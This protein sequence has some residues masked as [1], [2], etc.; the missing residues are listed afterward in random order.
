MDVLFIN[1][2]NASGIYQDLSK[3]YAAVEPPTWALLLAQSCRSVGYTVS[4]ID[5]NAEQ[6]DKEIAVERIRK[7]N[8]RLICLVVYGQNVNAGTVNMSGATAISSYIK[9]V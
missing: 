4:L 7:L 8:P 6:L 5:I 9:S 1:P 3:D 2:G